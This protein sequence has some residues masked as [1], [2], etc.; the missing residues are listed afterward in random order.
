MIE[1]I[2]EQGVFTDIFKNTCTIPPSNKD[3]L[4]DGCF[5]GWQ[6]YGCSKE[7]QILL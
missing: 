3:Q 7:G 4:C 2:K 1:I 5:S 6:P